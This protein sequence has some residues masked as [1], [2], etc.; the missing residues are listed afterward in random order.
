MSGLI[1]PGDEHTLLGLILPERLSTLVPTVIT[2]VEGLGERA[3]DIFSRLMNDQII[4]IN[5]P[6]DD[7]LAAVV[8]AQLLL[9]DSLSDK[10][11]PTPVHMW[12]NSGG[13]SITAGLAIYDMM[14]KI[15][16]PVHTYTTGASASMGTILHVAGDIGHRY[17][18]LN[19][20]MMIHQPSAGSEGQSKSTDIQIGAELIK[21]MGEQLY[22]IYALHCG[23]TAEHWRDLCENGDNWFRADAAIEVGLADLF[24]PSSKIEAL[25]ALRAKEDK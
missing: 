8:Q 15:D 22:E 24:I 14:Q 6:I 5:G 10:E 16:V 4:L 20:R 12:I 18:A 19:A 7:G 9:L 23:G 11:S 25:K 17:I 1:L 2:P 3:Q 13:G 21:D